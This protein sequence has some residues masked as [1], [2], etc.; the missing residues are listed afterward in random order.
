MRIEDLLIRQSTNDK[1]AIYYFDKS[2][3]YR[4]WYQESNKIANVIKNLTDNSSRNIGLYLPNSINYAVAYFG[5]L[6][7]KKVVIPIGIQAKFPEIFSTVEYC[8]LDLIITESKYVSEIINN[9]KYRYKLILYLIDENRDIVFNAE[10][11]FLNKTNTIFFEGSDDDVAIMLHTSGTT[12]NP[13]RVMLTHKNIIT[14]I[15]SNIASLMLTSNDKVLIALPMFFGYC[16]TA[17]FLTH[18]YLG[19]SMFIMNTIFFPKKFFEIVEKEHISNF[20]AVPTMLLM[21]LE[22]NYSNKY[23]YSS[24]RY[25]CFGGGIMPNSKLEKLIKKYTSIGFVQTYG[26]T[27]CSP[28]VTALLPSESLTK[29]GSVGLPIPNVIVEIMNDGKI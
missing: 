19:A 24:L 18:T 26:Q 28:R 2:L 17:Q 12:D 1:K 3:S 6:F 11:K 23:D 20:T 29:L 5:V 14:N 27:E 10:Q 9:M 16:N 22:Y 7:S 15:E 13:K 4:E 8:E 25:I 21:I